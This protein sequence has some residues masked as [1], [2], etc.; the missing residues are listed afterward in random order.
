MGCETCNGTGEIPLIGPNMAS[1]PDCE[2]TGETYTWLADF[3]EPSRYNGIWLPP[4]ASP[5]AVGVVVSD[6]DVIALDTGERKIIV[7][8]VMTYDIPAE[9]TTE[10]VIEIIQG[11][12][13]TQ[14][15]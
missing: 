14:T 10:E 8:D 12:E 15:I 2:E 7:N 9:L 11:L 3:Q 6:G 5:A 4:E 13:W 1:C